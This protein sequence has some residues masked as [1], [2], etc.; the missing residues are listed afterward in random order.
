MNAG[1]SDARRAEISRSRNRLSTA[2]SI[3]LRDTDCPPGRGPR[4]NL[5]KAPPLISRDTFDAIVSSFPN[6]SVADKQRLL[7][8]TL[9]EQSSRPGESVYLNY[10][11]L[12]PRVWGSGSEEACYLAD[13]L[14]DRGLIAFTQKSGDRTID[15]CQITPAGW[16]YLDKIENRTLDSSQAFVAMWFDPSMDAAWI[17]GIKPA[18]ED[19][20][21]MPY[22]VDNDLSDLGRIDA[23]IEVEIKR[24]RFLVADVTGGR[25]GVYYEAGYA[26]GLGLPVIWCV[27]SDRKDDMHFD[28]QQYKHIIWSTPQDLGEKL[29]ALVI[30]AIGEH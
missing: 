25:Q 26:L 3:K 10:R 21:Y 8:Q 24:S 13:A 19:A 14:H 15:H 7:I 20:G 17:D 1:S 18:L 27:R 6:Y 29:E 12:S 4:R 22:R 11:S 2:A 30:A 28:T 9:A 5:D 16:D 23:K